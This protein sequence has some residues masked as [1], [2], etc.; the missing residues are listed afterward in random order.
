MFDP[1]TNNTPTLATTAEAFR[2]WRVE[3]IGRGTTPDLLREQAVALLD[4]HSRAEITQ[5]LGINSTAFGQWVR[6]LRGN[7][8]LPGGR[9]RRRTP[10]LAMPEQFVELT[11]ADSQSVLPPCTAPVFAQSSG[12]SVA[13]LIIDLPN[14]TRIIARSADCAERLLT[15]L[16]LPGAS[17]AGAGS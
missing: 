12:N 4:E 14:G 2:E 6:A 11:A 1:T 17:T 15:H 13:E 3:R 7:A 9:R 5:A 10:V 8:A 16:C